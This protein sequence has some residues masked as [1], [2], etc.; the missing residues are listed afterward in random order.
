MMTVVSQRRK[1]GHLKNTFTRWKR[2]E[3]VIIVS[4]PFAFSCQL[5]NDSIGKY[6]YAFLTFSNF[7]SVHAL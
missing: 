2:E 1:Y 7:L 5:A 3:S 6:L 4:V